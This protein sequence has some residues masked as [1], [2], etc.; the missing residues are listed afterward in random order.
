MSNQDKQNSLI[1]RH[2]S[3][4]RNGRKN[5]Q[6]LI[7]GEVSPGFYLVRFLNEWVFGSRSNE[8]IIEV[9]EMKNWIFSETPAE[10]KEI[11][12]RGNGTIIAGRNAAEQINQALENKRLAAFIEGPE[13]LAETEKTG[14]GKCDDSAPLYRLS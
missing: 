13:M 4:I 5:L 10:D 11:V 12:I 14:E 3:T 7:L 8:R 1:G 6:G 2:F 9:R